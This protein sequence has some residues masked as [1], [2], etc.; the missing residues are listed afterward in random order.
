MSN[1][2]VVIIQKTITQAK[3]GAANVVALG[4]IQIFNISRK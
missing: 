2:I 4:I 1:V 3:A